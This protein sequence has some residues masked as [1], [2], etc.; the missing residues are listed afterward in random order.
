MQIK[1]NALTKMNKYASV[2]NCSRDHRE[3]LTK[4]FKTLTLKIFKNFKWQLLQRSRDG[5][6]RTAAIPT[7]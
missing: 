1:L 4:F 2:Q 7:A 5:N 6:G 3:D